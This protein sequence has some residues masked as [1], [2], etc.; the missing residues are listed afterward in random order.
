MQKLSVN[1]VRI[2]DIT[3]RIVPPEKP[4]GPDDIAKGVTAEELI[5]PLEKYQSAIDDTT[6]LMVT[7]KSHLGTHVEV[8]SHFWENGRELVDFP[9]E[10]WAGRMVFLKLDLE[11]KTLITYE[12]LE[13]ADNERLKENDIALLA[14]GYTEASKAPLITPEVAEFMVSK[15]V[16]LF[17]FDDSF[18]FLEPLRKT[19]FKI[20]DIL[21]KKD[22]PILE[23]VCNLDKLHQD[24]SILLAFP[25]LKVKGID[26][27]P[28]QAIVIEGIE[29]V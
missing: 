16:K 12:I 22:I 20:H 14:T 7:L 9:L 28:V 17:A 29:V 18:G 19:S 21:F 11:P 24:I 8:P 3:K 15:K 2:I 1:Q 23:H 5:Y 10:T 25:C 13:K 26:A 27:S 6:Y 4:F